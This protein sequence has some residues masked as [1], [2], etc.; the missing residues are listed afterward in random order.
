MGLNE[1]EDSMG[2]LHRQLEAQL[3]QKLDQQDLLRWAVSP[4]LPTCCFS[5]CNWHAVPS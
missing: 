3:L 1:V 2:E 4:A 5:T